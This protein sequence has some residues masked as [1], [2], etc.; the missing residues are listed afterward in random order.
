MVELYIDKNI[1]YKFKA[2]TLLLENIN[3]H[4]TLK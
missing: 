1:T 4:L 2:I 3:V